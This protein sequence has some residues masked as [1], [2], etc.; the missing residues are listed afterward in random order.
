M[1][2]L[3]CNDAGHVLACLMILASTAGLAAESGHEVRVNGRDAATFGRASGAAQTGTSAAVTRGASRHVADVQGRG[4]A[5]P[6]AS[7]ALARAGLIG[8]DDFGRAAGSAITGVR[9]PSK[10]NALTLMQ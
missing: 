10:L 7:G 8:V 3:N 5:T 9:A 6:S 2:K 1:K 4:S